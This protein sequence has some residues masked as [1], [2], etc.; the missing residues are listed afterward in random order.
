[1]F[2]RRTFLLFIL[3]NNLSASGVT[4]FNKTILKR[5]FSNLKDQI[6]FELQAQK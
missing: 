2:L 3:R 6:S 1:M 4:D 5:N